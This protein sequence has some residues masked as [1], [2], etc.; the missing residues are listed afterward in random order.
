MHD[1]QEVMAAREIVGVLDASPLENNFFEW[2]VNL[3]KPGRDGAN[4]PI[5]LM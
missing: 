3:W 1:H 2:H 5:H 4:Y